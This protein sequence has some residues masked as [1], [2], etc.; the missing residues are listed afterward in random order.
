M[1]ND[2]LPVLDGIVLSILVVMTLRGLFIG[3]IREA[4]SIA[5]LAAACVAV[6]YGRDPVAAALLSL[7]GASLPASVAP[8]I[9]GAGLAVLSIVVV[10]MLGR[11]I[12]RGARAVGLGWADRLGGAALGSA[13]GVLIGGLVTLGAIWAFGS[14]APS[15]AHSYS[16][17]AYETIRERVDFEEAGLPRPS[18]DPTYSG[19]STQRPC[20]RMMWISRSGASSSGT[21]RATTSCPTYRLTWPTP[22]PT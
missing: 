4:F 2:P 6:A 12:R 19:T 11:G 3:L 22:E 7:T 20:S 18:G 10:G 14:D 16:L 1:S 21:A 9:A 17:R 15:V 8:W 5:A 13:E